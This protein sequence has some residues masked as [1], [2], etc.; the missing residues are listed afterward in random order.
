[1]SNRESP[2]VSIITPPDNG[3]YEAINKGMK[4]AK[5]EILAYLN[6]DD[7][8]FPWTIRAVV[9]GFQDY[10]GADILYGDM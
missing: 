6:A 5:G 1:M 8:Y 4:Q 7:L 10:P 2:T 9:Q 3:M